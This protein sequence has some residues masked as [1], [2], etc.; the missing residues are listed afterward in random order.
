MKISERSGKRIVAVCDREL[1]GRVLSEGNCVLDLD[2]HASFYKGEP[3]DRADV[4]EALGRFD[5]ANLV[6]KKAVAIAVGLG[7]AREQDIRYI[8]GVPHVQVYKFS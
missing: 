6:G 2:S 8:N 5:S 3:A 7:I 4:E 1:I